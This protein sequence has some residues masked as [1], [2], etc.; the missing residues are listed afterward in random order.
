[1]QFR[2]WL[3]D[4]RSTELE[5]QLR[6]VENERD[7]LERRLRVAETEIESLAEVVARDRQRVAAETAE[8]A[9]RQARYESE[10]L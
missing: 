7:R 1:M 4:R 9:R 8:H 2:K 3:R 10:G 6:A 5:R